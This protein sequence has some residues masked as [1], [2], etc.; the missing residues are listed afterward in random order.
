MAGWEQDIEVCGEADSTRNPVSCNQA[1]TDWIYHERGRQSLA[2]LEVFCCDAA[3]FADIKDISLAC[4][5][6]YTK[7]DEAQETEVNR[8]FGGIGWSQG[9]M[10]LPP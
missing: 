3:H 9:S 1:T 2:S 6:G 5:V 4:T 7:I 8:D 10:R